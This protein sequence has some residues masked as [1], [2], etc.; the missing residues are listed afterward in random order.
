VRRQRSGARV[1]AAAAIA[2]L[3]ASGARAEDSLAPRG[4]ASDISWKVVSYLPNRVFDLCDV[5]RLRARFGTGFAAG[6]RVTRYVPFFV[7]D[8]GAVW[9]G[10]PGPRGRPSLPLPIGTEHQAGVEVGPMAAGN[11]KH[12]PLYGKGE[13]GAGG[14]LYLVGADVGVDPYEVV[15]FLAGFAL[16]DFAHDDY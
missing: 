11:Q 4:S 14:M 16:I 8:Y 5:V 2:W 7:G 15:D 3:G 13:I 1:C 6:A 10:L 12:A 9:V